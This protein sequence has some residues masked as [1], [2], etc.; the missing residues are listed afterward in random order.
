MRDLLSKDRHIA[1]L[2]GRT[3]YPEISVIWGL[4]LSFFLIFQA[5]KMSKEPIQYAVMITVVGVF[6]TR[7]IIY[8]FDIPNLIFRGK[9]SFHN[10]SA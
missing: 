3:I 7:M 9:N 1:A 8:I 2:D 5:H 6:V 10:E 4:M